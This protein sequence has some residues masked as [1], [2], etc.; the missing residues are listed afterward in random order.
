MKI[1]VY[2]GGRDERG[3][4]HVPKTEILRSMKAD[5][6]RPL[7]FDVM[8]S[9]V[10]EFKA[11]FWTMIRLYQAKYNISGVVLWEWNKGKP[12]AQERLA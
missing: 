12:Q 10:A 1:V 8:Q 5:T 3:R 7:V 11:R 4:F 2:T 9:A 6:Q